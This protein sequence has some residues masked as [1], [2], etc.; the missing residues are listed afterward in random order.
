MRP[1][2]LILV[3]LGILSYSTL[4]AQTEISARQD[5]TGIENI[6]YEI[7]EI[8]NSKTY[9]NG[10]RTSYVTL[11][12]ALAPEKATALAQK[13][14]ENSNIYRFSFWNKSDYRKIMFKTD[15]SISEEKVVQILNRELSSL[16]NTSESEASIQKSKHKERI[17]VNPSE[18]KQLKST[19]KQ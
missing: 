15:I 14:E 18:L 17:F 6:Q 1:L 7:S 13:M 16:P 19:P 11:T 4:S 9:D 8:D 12:R 2:L 3:T 5:L 10:R